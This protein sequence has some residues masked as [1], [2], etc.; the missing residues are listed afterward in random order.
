VIVPKLETE[1]CEYLHQL[2]L[3]QQR[4]VLAFVRALVTAQ[5]HGVQ[6]S[7]CSALRERSTRAT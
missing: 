5:V 1:I 3:E 2:S 7:H 6:G 4:H